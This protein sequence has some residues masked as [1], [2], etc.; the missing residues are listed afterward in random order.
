MTTEELAL[1]QIGLSLTRIEVKLDDMV[2]QGADHEARLRAVESR[3]NVTGK[4]LW[5]GLVG[6]AGVASAFAVVLALFIR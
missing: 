2:R 1:Q 6:S 3:G 5:A 4:Q